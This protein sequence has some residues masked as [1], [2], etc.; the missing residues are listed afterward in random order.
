MQA[1]ST[2]SDALKS[3]EPTHVSIDLKEA[4]KLSRF[5]PA[6]KLSVRKVAVAVCGAYALTFARC[7]VSALLG[8][9]SS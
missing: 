3:V 7:P 5:R 4:L 8:S 6:Q 9:F 1:E 2:I